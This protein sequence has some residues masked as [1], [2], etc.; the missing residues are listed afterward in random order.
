MKN[1]LILINFGLYLKNVLPGI[2]YI[3][4]FFKNELIL[5]VPSFLI[6]ETL[7]FLRDHTNCQFKLISDICA[8]DY[9]KKKN[10]FEIVYNILSIRYN[11]KLRIKTYVNELTP[12]SSITSIYSCAN[13]WER[14]IWDMFGVFFFK[15]SRFKTNFN[16][17][18]L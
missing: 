3:E 13:W 15:P 4:T 6:I 7:L 11:T 18:W 2:S 5:T 10:R 17:L 8:V 14:E 1:N 12:I 16:R 9:L